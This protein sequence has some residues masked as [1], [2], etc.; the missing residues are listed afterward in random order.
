MAAPLC[1]DTTA[2][3]QIG[4]SFRLSMPAIRTTFQAYSDLIEL[5]A[6]DAVLVAKYKAVREALPNT[7]GRDTI[8]LTA[9]KLLPT[10]PRVAA[11]FR[12]AGTTPEMT[13][14]TFETLLG[15]MF[16]DG[17]LTS[18][19]GTDESKLPAFVAEN[20]AFYRQNRPAIESEF[21]QFAA[22]AASLGKGAFDESDDSEEAEDEDEPEKD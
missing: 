6:A 14:N 12:K 21:K 15:V 5:L 10:E 16:G 3:R 9:A 22:K 20:L 4:E 19:K 17:M 8:G 13:A 7:N 11:V 1:A 2:A 18:A